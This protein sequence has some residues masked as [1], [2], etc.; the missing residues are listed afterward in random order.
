M[1]WKKSDGT[2]ESLPKKDCDM[3]V[4]FNPNLITE[5]EG[6]DSPYPSAGEVVGNFNVKPGRFYCYVMCTDSRGTYVNYLSTSLLDKECYYLE[7][8][9][10]PSYKEISNLS[11]K[12]K[13]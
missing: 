4:L 13:D 9:K 10:Y 8:P 3:L 7:I 11:Q 12:I 1:Q 5:I 2:R 6:K